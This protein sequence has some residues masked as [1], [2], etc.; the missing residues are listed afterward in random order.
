[1]KQT[2]ESPSLVEYGRLE[3]LTLGQH[4]TMPDYHIGGSQMV[5]DN[6]LETGGPGESGDSK[7]FICGPGGPGS[8]GS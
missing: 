5:N 6:C 2:Y 8:F 7:P 4:G 1:M 3:A